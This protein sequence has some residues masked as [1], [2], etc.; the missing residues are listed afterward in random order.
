MMFA[1]GKEQLAIQHTPT[2]DCPLRGAATERIWPPP[3][4]TARRVFMRD[5]AIWKSVHR[6]SRPGVAVAFNEDDKWVC[7]AGRDKKIH[8]WD[9]RRQSGWR[10]RRLDDDIFRLVVFEKSIFSC[11]RRQ[12]SP[13]AFH[14]QKGTGPHFFRA[15]NDW[16]YSAGD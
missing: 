4:A 7:S 8:L 2:G 11:F 13:A 1:A 5:D 3:V 12:E 15:H 14:G 6:A 10:N 9:Q 16:V